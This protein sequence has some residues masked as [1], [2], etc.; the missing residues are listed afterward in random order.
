MKVA[1]KQQGNYIG[2]MN[3]ELF[4]FFRDALRIAVFNP[5]MAFFLYGFLRKLKKASLLR[6]HWKTKGIHVPPYMIASITSRCNL[7]CKG[8]YARAHHRSETEELGQ[9]R[10]SEI[11]NDAEELGISVILLAGG[12]PFTRA[13]VISEA[14]KHKKI[15]FPVFTN[16][17]L[18]DDEMISKL[19]RC[20]NIVPIISIEGLEDNTD[21][22]RGSGVFENALKVMKKFKDNSIFF[23]VSLT[24]T[25]RNMELVTGEHFIK[26]LIDTGCKLFIYV[27]YV[28]IEEDTAY[29]VLDDSQRLKLTSLVYELHTKYKRLF[30]S[31]PGDEEK[32]GGCLAAGRGFVHVSPGGSLEPCPFSPYSDTNLKNTSLKDALNSDL[33]SEI[34]KG[35]DMLTETRG[36]CALWN[37]RDWV[38]SLLNNTRS[39]GE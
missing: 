35:H 19:K 15:V 34:R 11:F 6:N 26:K 13:E 33:L 18:I 20:R 7:K 29:L 12:E 3:S 38:V 39:L 27:E 30:L 28:P 24:A 37:N 36:G 31:F 4:S 32:F 16:G 23:G 10:W 5:G 9:E 21:E 17:M 1:P 14:D 2:L 8:C 22:R 25:S